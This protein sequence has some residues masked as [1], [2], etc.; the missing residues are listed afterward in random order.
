MYF[1]YIIQCEDG[2]FYTGS[3][4]DPEERFRKHK[5][6]NGGRYTRSHRPIKLIYTE[7]FKSKSD[8]LKREIQIKDWTRKKKE[9]LI[10]L[11]RP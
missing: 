6:G 7:G 3:S 10:R 5:A 2:S 4:P 1:V 9:N 11:G 8:A